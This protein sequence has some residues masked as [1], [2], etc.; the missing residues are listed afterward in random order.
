[1][2]KRKTTSIMTLFCEKRPKAFSWIGGK[3]TGWRGYKCYIVERGRKKSCVHPVTGKK[4]K[5]VDI[6]HLSEAPYGAA[7]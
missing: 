7:K 3:P 5:C 6:A 2:P 1:M 4:V